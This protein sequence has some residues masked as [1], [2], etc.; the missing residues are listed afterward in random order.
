MP[1]RSTRYQGAIIWEGKIL[2]IRHQEHNHGRDY[3][4]LPGGGRLDD[5]SEEQCVVREI[6]E[7]TNLDV[8]VVRL[9]LDMRLDN[10]G[11]YQRFKTYLCHP[12]SGNAHPGYE[13][14]PEAA[15]IYAIVEVKWI[16]QWDEN[17]WGDKIT[18]DPI[19]Y[20]LLKRIQQALI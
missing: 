5:E 17:T 16:D 19:T 12:I 9:L 3:W 10:P 6:K 2:L 1:G 8:Q 14:E 4:L 18:G 7:E 20:P 13:P 15:R 11:V